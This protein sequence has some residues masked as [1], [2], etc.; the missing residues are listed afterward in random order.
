MVRPFDVSKFRSGLTKSI[1][2][3]STGFESDPD[4]WIST[5]NY[6]LNYLMLLEQYWGAIL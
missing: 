4:T 1:Q 6:T 2:G 5:G 3:I